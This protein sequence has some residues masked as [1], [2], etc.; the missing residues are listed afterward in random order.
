[1]IRWLGRAVRFGD[2]AAIWR[3]ARPRQ[4]AAGAGWFLGRFLDASSVVVRRWGPSWARRRHVFGREIGAWI[5]ALVWL[6]IPLALA[7]RA[8]RSLFH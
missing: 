3:A 5:L 1:M 4:P 7:L 2:H 6:G 8:A